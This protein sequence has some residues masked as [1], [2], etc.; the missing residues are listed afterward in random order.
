MIIKHEI[1]KGAD[2][3]LKNH[4]YVDGWC[5]ETWFKFRYVDHLWILYEGHIPVGVAAIQND[6]GGVFVKEEFRNRGY[7]SALIRVMKKEK[8]VRLTGRA[9]ALY[10]NMSGA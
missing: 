2:I 9:K 5:F 8:N 4:L 7:G 6:I 10:I 1:E 3:A